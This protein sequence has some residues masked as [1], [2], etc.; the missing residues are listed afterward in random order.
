MSR[1]EKF[2]AIVCHKS[3]EGSLNLGSS[4]VIIL[5]SLCISAEILQN[6]I[7]ISG[8]VL[9]LPVIKFRG[10]RNHFLPHLSVLLSFCG[11][12]VKFSL[13]LHDGQYVIPC[14]HHSTTIFASIYSPRFLHISLNIIVMFIMAY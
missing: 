9:I 7:I 13:S 1:S 10:V 11:V 5:S 2:L 14:H 3:P 6:C 8:S 12:S 4:L